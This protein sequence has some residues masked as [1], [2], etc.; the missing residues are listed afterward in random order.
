MDY[1]ISSSK[2]DRRYNSKNGLKFAKHFERSIKLLI[3]Q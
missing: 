2:R 1:A 3:L